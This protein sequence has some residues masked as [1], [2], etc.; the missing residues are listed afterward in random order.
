VLVH[1]PRGSFVAD[2]FQ[3]HRAGLVVD[4]P[5]VA[6][7]AEG[8]RALATDSD[9]RARLTAQAAA[10]GGEFSTAESRCRFWGVVDGLTPPGKTCQH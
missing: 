5:D 7:V 3:R 9:L 1:A 4:E 6:Q 8:L 10:A 2:F